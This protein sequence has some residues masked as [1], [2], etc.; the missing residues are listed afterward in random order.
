MISTEET[1]V[2]T[3]PVETTIEQLQALYEDLDKRVQK[4]E[5]S[6]M[7]KSSNSEARKEK[8][9]IIECLDLMEEAGVANFENVLTNEAAS[10]VI[11][12]GKLNN[13][14]LRDDPGGRR[15]ISNIIVKRY[16]FDFKGRRFIKDK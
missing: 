1:T 8:E 2:Q 14:E 7:L 5:T 3:V 12:F 16:H 6:K 10:N 9:K 4:L 11:M 15:V 13:I